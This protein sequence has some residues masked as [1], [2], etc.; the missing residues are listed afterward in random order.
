MDGEKN[1]G[2]QYKYA[3]NNMIRFINIIV[4]YVDVISNIV[5]RQW[6]R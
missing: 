3:A 2:K 5:R 1:T 6:G 4:D